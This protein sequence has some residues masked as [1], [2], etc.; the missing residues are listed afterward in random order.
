MRRLEQSAKE[1]RGVHQL[2]PGRFL[3][4]PAAHQQQRPQATGIQVI[5]IRNIQ[6][7]HADMIELFDP[8]PELVERGSAHHASGTVHN[9]YILQAFDL[10]FEFHMSIH[11]NL[12]WKKF[13]DPVSLYWTFD[14][15]NWYK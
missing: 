8:A 3:Y 5:N 10:K 13:H 1:S 11:T 4:G 12:L 14:R 9:R 6:H 7:Q 15:R 2:Q